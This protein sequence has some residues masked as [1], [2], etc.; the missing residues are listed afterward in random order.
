MLK[1]PMNNRKMSKRVSIYGRSLQVRE[2]EFC[3][4][5]RPEYCN[6][7][8]FEGLAWMERIVGLIRK[9]AGGLCG[10]KNLVSVSTTH[11]GFIPM[12]AS[13]CFDRVYLMDTDPDHAEDI[14]ANGGGELLNCPE[15]LD[16]STNVW[17]CLSGSIPHGFCQ[18]SIVLT[19]LTESVVDG[20]VSFVFEEVRIHVSPGAL[21]EFERVLR[22]YIGV[23]RSIVYDNLINLCIMVRNAGPLF[24]RILRENMNIIDRW[25]IL[26]TGSTDE[27]LEIIERVLVGKKEGGL[28][29]EPFINFRDSRNRLLDL[30]GKE[31][32]FN[33]MLDDTYIVRGDLRAFLTE[34]RSDQYSSSFQVMIHSDD[35]VY[36]SNRITKSACGLRYIHKI[37][38]IINDKGN[39]IVLIPEDRAWIEDIRTDEMH[40][41]SM[42]RK[43]SDIV[44][45][46][47]ELEDDP[48]NPRTYYYLAQTYAQTGEFDKALHF[49]LERCRFVDS[50]F[51]QERVD[52]MIEAARIASHRLGRPWEECEP[53]F[54]EAYRM[55]PRRPEGPYF[56]GVHYF[57]VGDI[58]RAHKH[59]KK[60]FEIGFPEVC[61][62]SLRP[63][64]S[65]HFAPKLLARCCYSVD[66]FRTGEACTAFF[67]QHNDGSADDYAEMA[68]WHE[69]YK[70]LNI[71]EGYMGK[72]YCP[73][74]PVCCFVA[75]GGFG[76][77]WNGSS[78]R[79]TG[80][81]G[82]ETHTIEMARRIRER[83][84]FDVWVFC[85][86]PN[87]AT[88]VCDGVVYTSLDNFY[89]FV[90]TTYVHSCIVSR[91]SEYI[92]V[93]FRGYA[94]RVFLFLHDLSPSGCV[95]P[96]DPKLRRIF[97]LSEWHAGFFTSSF[98]TL[99]DKTT[100]LY[101]GI[102]DSRFFSD[103]N[104][105]R[106]RFIYSSMPDRGLVV[107]LRMWPRIREMIPGARLDVFCDIHHPWCSRVQPAMMDEVRSTLR[108]FSEESHGVVVH[109]WVPKERL[110]E[111]WREAGV[112][113]YPCIFTET[114]CL[115]ALEA[116]LS[117]TLAITNHLGALAETVGDRGI[118]IDGDPLTDEWQT[119]A[120]DALRDVL[121]RKDKADG[122]IDRNQ[123]WA[124]AMT[125]SRQA[126]RLHDEHLMAD[127][128]EVKGMFNWTHDIPAGSRVV[129][130]GILDRFGSDRERTRILEVGTYTGT[131]LIEMVRRI[132]GSEGCGL[133]AWSDYEE[134][135]R[136]RHIQDLRVMD[137]FFANIRSH[138]LEDR[139][140]AVRSDSVSAMM[141]WIRSGRTFDIIYVDGCHRALD[142][143]ADLVL[144]W[145]LLVD[146]G[147]FIIDDYLFRRDK[148]LDSPYEA[149]N[150]FIERTSCRVLHSGYRVFLEK[151]LKIQ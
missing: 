26:D 4:I 115:T 145:E 110:A 38:E 6:L 18:G 73:P 111:G 103:H 147:L 150:R 25:T 121:H 57:D 62:F 54:E 81:G 148:V 126:D 119:R 31:C 98:P 47:E 125:W 34:T 106:W 118:I 149:V 75:D 43:Q 30:A 48:Q 132:P 89:K 88:E 8:M 60:A 24:E 138:G 74:K 108:R 9:I 84:V 10:T 78:I 5:N 21:D 46:L 58:P 19:P 79:T 114:F 53:M 7:R 105:D 129:F 76:V 64:L 109:G 3:R 20:F 144:A 80:V 63:T 12:E 28:Y 151:N 93:A 2:H 36:G 92:P 100:S 17:L 15:D 68:S 127:P 146:G 55:D 113:L 124:S 44:L 85:N 11:G 94:D 72:P 59:L 117:R 52:S 116:A 135:G 99:T 70:R 42:D 41:R 122:L 83:G 91:F 130:E 66:D 140:T 95:I 32:K 87:G 69:I 1:I 56:M 90:G 86:T 141:G 82:S 16:D 29:R 50:G 102:D 142:C 14:R 128:I 37:H 120:L 101:Y 137:S 27:T 49:F 104:G 123:E 136:V 112:W 35:F 71:L 40:R 97:C 107:L 134:D 13:G 51:S 133:D 96:L 22:Y 139:I 67:L 143:Y 45:L 131:S 77:G 65:F 39:T 61:Q 33:I 23:D